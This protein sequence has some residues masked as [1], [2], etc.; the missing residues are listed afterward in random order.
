LNIMTKIN[1]MNYQRLLC[2]FLSSVVLAVI[3]QVK[4]IG[5]VT[6]KKYDLDIVYIGNSITEGGQH[7]KPEV[8]APPATASDYLRHKTGV[9]SVT[10]S[11]Q[12]RSGYTTVDYLPS[13][14]GALTE[15]ITAANSLH[16]DKSRLLIFSISLGTNDSAEKGPNGSPVS[17]D[18]Y[19]KNIEAIS[20]K[21]LSVFPDCKIILQ[22]PIWYSPNTYNSSEYMAKGLARLQTYFPILKAVVKKYS[23][24]NPG[25]LFTGDLTGFNY[26]RKNYLTDLLP[27]SGNAGTFYLHPNTKGSAV[28]GSLWG[29]AIYNR[30]ISSR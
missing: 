21:L 7:E 12:G 2:I 3:S 1:S 24:T 4:L 17:P 9:N 30:I 10:F 6:E 28:L 16:N 8:E 27:E 13:D 15:V 23:E 19:Q 14:G 20:E 29:E 25:H 18:N 22:Q 11:N 5:Q 26:F